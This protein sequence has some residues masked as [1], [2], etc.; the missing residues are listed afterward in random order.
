MIFVALSLL[1]L[2][3]LPDE[4]PELVP[5]LEIPEDRRPEPVRIIR[6]RVLNEQGKAANKV[7]FRTHLFSDQERPPAFLRRGFHTNH[8]GEFS[9]EYRE[10]Q[11][12]VT[13]FVVFLEAKNGKP[14][15]SVTVSLPT[16]NYEGVIEMGDLIMREAPIVL[17]GRVLDQKGNGIPH[18][19][20]AL[21]DNRRNRRYWDSHLLV[22][23]ADEAGAFQMHGI[24]ASQVTFGETML[25]RHPDYE[26]LE[27]DVILRHI[28][29]EFTLIPLQLVRAT[30]LLPTKVSPNSV[31]IEFLDQEGRFTSPHCSLDSYSESKDLQWKVNS[32]AVSLLLIDQD[33]Q[34]PFWGP[35]QL[36]ELNAEGIYDLG[37]VDLREQIGVAKVGVLQ[38]TGQRARN[39]WVTQHGYGRNGQIYPS[40]FEGFIKVIFPKANPA[41]QIGASGLRMETV[42]LKDGEQ[43]ITLSP[44]IPLNL[45]IVNLPTLPGEMTIAAEVMPHYEGHHYYIAEP[46]GIY[47]LVNN[48]IPIRVSHQGTYVVYLK[49]GCSDCK[50]RFSSSAHFYVKT[51]EVEGQTLKIVLDQMQIQ[52]LLYLVESHQREE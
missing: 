40:Y 33:N 22:T 23:S 28:G 30:I 3:Q 6:G 11:E 10:W 50:L 48:K 24:D 25:I 45:E 14:P 52:S 49:L 35:L 37:F 8:K 19:E 9:Q 27:R 13:K 31:L 16:A 43:E 51:P 5:V 17:T 44:G 46:P 36:G 7:R 42:H 1:L 34:T 15:R 12:D 39:V 2:P 29:Q 32:K 20:I 18:A 21:V 26:T 38:P 41:F 4:P 47:R